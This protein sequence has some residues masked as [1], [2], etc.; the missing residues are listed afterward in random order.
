[1]NFLLLNGQLLLLPAVVSQIAP[2]FKVK[3]VIMPFSRYYAISRQKNATSLKCSITHADF[4]P[5]KYISTELPRLRYFE[6]AF[7]LP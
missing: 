2:L 4:S 1:M 6:I 5:R 7:S 3:I